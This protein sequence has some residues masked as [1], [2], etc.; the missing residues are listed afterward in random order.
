[1]SRT[2]SVK[3]TAVVSGGFDPSPYVREGVTA[4]EVIEIKTAFDLFDADKGGVIEPKGI[5]HLI[6]KSKMLWTL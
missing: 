6:Q 5:K 4:D 3:T 2:A 1:M